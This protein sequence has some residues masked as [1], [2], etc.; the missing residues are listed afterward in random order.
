MQFNNEDLLALAGRHQRAARATTADASFAYLLTPDSD[1]AQFAHVV[2]FSGRAGK[3][4]MINGLKDESRTAKSKPQSEKEVL[5]VLSS[6]VPQRPTLRKV[7]SFNTSEL[8]P[9]GVPILDHLTAR[10]QDSPDWSGVLP[11]LEELRN[12]RLPSDKN[13]ENYR[14]LTLGESSPKEWWEALQFMN[15][16]LEQDRR[17][18]TPFCAADTESVQ[19]SMNW[20]RSSRESVEDS[21]L[22]HLKEQ[23]DEGATHRC[24]TVIPEKYSTHKGSKA[25]LPVRFMLGGRDWQVHIRLPTHNEKGKNEVYMTLTL[26]T[27]LTKEV[28]D[29]LKAIPCAVGVDIVKDYVSWARLLHTLWG[30]TAF[31]EVARPIELE[32]LV[33][34]VRVNDSSGSIFHLHWWVFGTIIPKDQAS[35]GDG[36]WGSELKNL[37]Q[38]LRMYLNCDIEQVVKITSI[39]SIVWAIQTFPDLTLVKDATLMDEVD[40]VNWVQVKAIPELFAGWQEIGV[41]SHGRWLHAARNSAW[42]ETRSIT[43]LVNQLNPPSRS[44]YPS[45]WEVPAWPSITCGGC[46]FL[47]QARAV[48]IKMLE[49]LHRMDPTVWPDREAANKEK[50]EFWL[51]GVDTDLALEVCND[52]VTVRGLTAR[53]DLQSKLP[54]NPFTWDLDLHF[55]PSKKIHKAGDRAIILHHMRLNVSSAGAVLRFAEEDKAGFRKVVKQ[56]KILKTVIDMRNMLKFLNLPVIRPRGWIDPYKVDGYISWINKKS[57]AHLKRKL[58]VF[59][60]SAEHYATRIEQ[61][62]TVLQR[63]KQA[64]RF[65]TAYASSLYRAATTPGDPEIKKRRLEAARAYEA[66][67]STVRTV[68]YVEDELAEPETVNPP[69]VGREADAK[70]VVGPGGDVSSEISTK[71]ALRKKAETAPKP[72]FKAVD[73]KGVGREK[74]ASVVENTTQGSAQKIFPITEEME[75]SINN[76]ME[77]PGATH[78]APG[79]SFLINVD[80]LK[81]LSGREYLNDS[82]VEGYLQLLAKRGGQNGFPTVVPMTTFF[83]TNLA[84]KGH[85][86]VA[87]YTKNVDIFAA[88]FFLIPNHLDVHW[89][90]TVVDMASGAITTYDSMKS[91]N[92]GVACPGI[93]LGYLAQEHWT[94]KHED[95][96]EKFKVVNAVNVP[97]QVGGVDCGVFAC[98]FAE[99]IT[100]R[101]PLD[102][103]Q[104]DMP[105]FRQLM[106]WELINQTILPPRIIESPQQDPD[107][108]STMEV[109]MA[110]PSCK[111][112]EEANEDIL[113]LNCEFEDFDKF[114]NL[115]LGE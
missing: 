61:A 6:Q 80:D 91:L 96:P 33:R 47:H 113:D 97:Q 24:F 104:A 76:T 82:V 56:S 98:R 107:S 90:L 59:H 75:Q 16:H 109:D 62:E 19:V 46:R 70:H 115:Y 13:L 12:S 111:A 42:E 31:Q 2:H 29:F 63:G 53:S 88:D 101:A 71:T 43:D 65:K 1:Q 34:A 60:K 69:G 49:D 78:I 112:E 26:D 7:G 41:D 95:L 30:N 17:S 25:S 18:L 22:G 32:H 45:V 20:D 44:V 89:T 92:L 27:Q 28:D 73:P 67:H 10:V 64:Q 55:N 3:I 79:M 106:K 8:L 35:L 72:D 57:E 102:F 105:H 83:Y 87:R 74:A 37:P 52:P 84:N 108:S 86:G 114:L 4:D 103:C 48:T 54:L 85:K 58:E 36:M 50:R 40:F 15:H 66:E 14:E 51:F 68:K 94:R 77:L 23:I 5:Q 21:L 99:V 93:I 39:L 11:V 9:G 81:S 110:P 38:G 100:R